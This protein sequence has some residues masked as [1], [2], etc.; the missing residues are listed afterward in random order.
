MPK[1]MVRPKTFFLSYATARSAASVRTV[2]PTAII[3]G[4]VATAG[5]TAGLRNLID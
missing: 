5:C 4:V 1:A 3:A 2:W